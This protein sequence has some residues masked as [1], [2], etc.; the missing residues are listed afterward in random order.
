MAPA[1]GGRPL[2]VVDRRVMRVAMTLGAVCPALRAAVVRVLGATVGVTVTEFFPPTLPVPP[3]L[4]AARP[5]SVHLRRSSLWR[6]W[7]PLVGQSTQFVSTIVSAAVGGPAAAAAVPEEETARAL[8]ALEALVDLLVPRGDGE[9][10]GV[11]RL[12]MAELFAADVPVPVAAGASA[13]ST[14]SPVI[15][16]LFRLAEEDERRPFLRHL[17]ALH[18]PRNIESVLAPPDGTAA[19]LVGLEQGGHPRL[20]RAAAAAA[21]LLCRVGS[22]GLRVLSVTSDLPLVAPISRVSRATAEVPFTCAASWRELRHLS[23]SLS[24]LS[25]ESMRRGCDSLLALPKWAPALTHLTLC[26]NWKGPMDAA[27]ITS[28]VGDLPHL[29]SLDTMDLGRLGFCSSDLVVLNRHGR[30]RRLRLRVVHAADP[31][32]SLPW[33]AAWA[34][35]RHSL[36]ELALAG[37]VPPCA[38]TSVAAAVAGLATSHPKVMAVTVVGTDHTVNE[39]RSSATAA[40]VR[41]LSLSLVS[42]RLVNGAAVDHFFSRPAPQGASQA[43][44]GDTAAA[45]ILAVAL[46]NGWPV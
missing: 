18:I 4:A 40:A 13:I 19:D 43:P 38:D 21:D 7:R 34:P 28:V 44:V 27:A 29:V 22:A 23:L 12:C 37:V 25:E 32:G 24:Y 16:L 42:L 9:G 35:V 20:S 39:A 30:L 14:G 41:L 1:A 15:W 46:R 31:I 5:A 6:R 26:S 33:A 10:G 45:G 8:A 11:R 3:L 2:L 36:A 17:T